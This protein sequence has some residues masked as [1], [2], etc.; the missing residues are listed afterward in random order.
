MAVPRPPRIRASA[1]RALA[2]LTRALLRTASFSRARTEAEALVAL[3]PRSADAFALH[4]ETLWSMGLF[5]ESEQR[6]REALTL[7]ASHARAHH[8]LARTLTGRRQFA[9]A[10]DHVRQALAARPD[11]YEFHHTEGFVFDRLGRYSD[12]ADSLRRFQALMPAHD[13]EQRTL[14]VR[15][16]IGFL[17]SFRGRTPF[18][19]DPAIAAQTH[20]VP[21]RVVRD[22]IVVE[23]RING[24]RTLELVLDT[25][26]E[27]TVVGRRTAERHGIAPLGF[28]V[29][30]GVGEAGLRGLQLARLDELS[31]GTFTMR[32]VPC[33]SRTR[34]L[35]GLPT[36]EGE[37]WSPLALG[38]STTI[39][40]GRRVLTFGKGPLPA[41]ELEMPLYLHRLATVRG[42]VDGRTRRTSSWTR[43]GKSSRSA[44]PWRRCWDRAGCAASRSRCTASSGWD[45]DAFLYPGLDLAFDRI[46]FDNFPVVVLNLK[47]PSALLGFELGG[48]VGHRF[49]SRYRVGLD[50]DAG[51]LRLTSL[52]W[53]ERFASRRAAR[54]PRA[55]S[56]FAC[57]LS[58][59][60]N[61]AA[62]PAAGR[63]RRRR[64]RRSG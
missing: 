47:A 18:E 39:D 28:T 45:R 36:R 20:T 1:A 26:A 3:Q 50:L 49:L 30:A 22:K 29:S 5:P 46:R 19:V 25:G 8:G 55:S 63:R 52:L 58:R 57:V 27:M 23:G 48:I 14:L 12:A 51:K 53:S 6:F 9:E 32:N 41:G 31:I 10:L 4:G 44:P 7:D 54:R 35:P 17:D 11:E 59:L 37:S 42:T 15:A 2:G 13:R 34:T 60:E 61:A 24:G 16:Q 64:R 43:A 21:F 62:A 33:S 56:A 40:Y 38:L